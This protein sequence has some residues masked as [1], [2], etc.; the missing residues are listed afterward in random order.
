MASHTSIAVGASLATTLAGLIYFGTLTHDAMRD[1]PAVA[2]NNGKQSEYKRILT[3]SDIDTLKKKGI[4]ILDTDELSLSNK[5]LALCLKQ[6]ATLSSKQL[7]LNQ[8][9]D[10]SV[11]SDETFF[12]SE[13]IEGQKSV[14]GDADEG[15]MR[16]LRTI[17]R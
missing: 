4:V 5:D 6:V 1:S 16:A 12:I 17:R 3:R 10:M 11:R 14:F 15:L 8:N 2:S 13:P 9:N 7:Q